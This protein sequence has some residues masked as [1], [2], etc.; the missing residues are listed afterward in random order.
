MSSFGAFVG[1]AVADATV[2]SVAFFSSTFAHETIVEI[3]AVGVFVAIVG[4]ECAFIN[5]D[6]AFVSVSNVTFVAD[7]VV[8]G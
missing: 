1:W 8:S 5:W 6:G 2:S 7:A 4:S 3:D